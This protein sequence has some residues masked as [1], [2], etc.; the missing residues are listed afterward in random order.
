MKKICIITLGIVLSYLAW[1]GDLPDSGI[2]IIKVT[3]V[4]KELCFS[5]PG[6]PVEHRALLR[7]PGAGLLDA[8]DLVVLTSVDDDDG[9]GLL[10]PGHAVDMVDLEPED[11]PPAGVPGDRLT[12]ADVAEEVVLRP[13]RDLLDLEREGRGL[14]PRAGGV[15]AERDA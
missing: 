11:V 15:C 8:Q 10:R 13:R 14:G 12:L 3:V 2:G 6:I 4:E 7:I 1:A 5:R 9:R